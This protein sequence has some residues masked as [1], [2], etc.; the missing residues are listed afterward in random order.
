MAFFKNLFGGKDPRSSLQKGIRLLSEGRYAEARGCLEDAA[1]RLGGDDG[2]LR[3]EI[4]ARQEEAGDALAGMNLEEAERCLDDGDVAKAHDHLE[5]AR[6]FAV[7]KSLRDRTVQLSRRLTA[8]TA[9]TDPADSTEQEGSCG[10]CSG[11]A[12]SPGKSSAEPQPAASDGHLSA[13]ERFELMTAALPDDLPLRYRALGGRFAEAY[14]LSHDG[15]DEAAA[16]ILGSIT[17]PA[18]QDII[19]YELA[20]IRHRLGEQRECEALLRQALRVND[21]NSLCCLA[22]VDLFAGTGRSEE[23]LLLLDAMISGELLPAQALMI[24]GDLQE[25]LGMEGEALEGYARLLETSYKKE[26]ATKI[27]PILEKLGRGEEARRI[28]KQYIKGCC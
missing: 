5:L 17:I 2:A 20:L 15:D 14:L 9:V 19:L 7:A 22:L 21:R 25:Q 23:A 3:G 12:S 6:R 18:S 8:M 1:E 16:R 4:A 24:R 10:S 13:E 26:A 11:G 28:F 27:I